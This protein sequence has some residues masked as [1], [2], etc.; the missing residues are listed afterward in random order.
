MGIIL[1]CLVVAIV[2]REPHPHPYLL[3]V[4]A[5]PDFAAVGFRLSQQSDWSPSVGVLS[6]LRA[7]FVLTL[8]FYSFAINTYGW[9]R[10]G[11]NNVLIFEFDPRNNLDFVQL[12]EVSPVS[13]NPVPH[14]CHPSLRS[15]HC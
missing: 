13:W 4:C 10:G 6:G 5:V 11:V 8:W 14:F 12:T 7:P 15:P 3:I 9:R 1:M 2:M